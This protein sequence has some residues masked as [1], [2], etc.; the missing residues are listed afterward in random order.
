MVGDS[1]TVRSSYGG[2]EI[3]VDDEALFPWPAVM[4][5]ILD[6][7]QDLWLKRRRGHLLIHSKP[8]AI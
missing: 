3:R 7:G 1:A 5:A 8:P 4:N 6:V 2:L